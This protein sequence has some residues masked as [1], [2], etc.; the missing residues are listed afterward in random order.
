MDKELLQSLHGQDDI[1]EEGALEA[2]LLSD[3]DSARKEPLP[4]PPKVVL[5]RPV[6]SEMKIR[7]APGMQ[8]SVSEARSMGDGWNIASALTSSLIAG[9]L[10]G[11]ALDKWVTAKWAP[12][13]LIAGFLLGCVSGFANLIKLT[14][15]MAARDAAT[16]KAAEMSASKPSDT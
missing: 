14:N 9:V 2:K 8:V 1:D 7:G 13:G 15:R 3:V 6:V 11:L 10:V 4:D 16:S 5:E 12:A